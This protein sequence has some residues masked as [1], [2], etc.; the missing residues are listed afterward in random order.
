MA[1][2]TTKVPDGTTGIKLEY[3]EVNWG[4][5]AQ[6]L[7]T[8]IGNMNQNLLDVKRDVAEIKEKQ[9]RSVTTKRKT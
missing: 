8:M 2:K 5:A 4:N 1:K 3:Q 9:C 6:L 7:M